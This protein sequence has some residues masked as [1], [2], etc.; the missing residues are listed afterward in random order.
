MKMTNF[1][2]KQ[3]VEISNMHIHN[4]GAVELE[5]LALIKSAVEMAADVIHS[6]RYVRKCKAYEQ[7]L[8][9][10]AKVKKA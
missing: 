4:A 6:H 7:E 8:E 1:S 5:K 9:Q 3:W 2:R 10:L